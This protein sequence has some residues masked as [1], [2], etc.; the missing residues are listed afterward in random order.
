MQALQSTSCVPYG[1]RRE[2]YSSVA[3]YGASPSNG[4]YIAVYFAV[5]A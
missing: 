4:Y 3:L 5:V 2:H 1:A